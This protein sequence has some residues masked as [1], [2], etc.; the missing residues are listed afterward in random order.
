MRAPSWPLDARAPAAFAV[1]VAVALSSSGRAGADAD[2]ASL[3][4]QATAGLARTRDHDATG[5]GPLVG[6]SAR[7]TL[8][9]SDVWAYEVTAGGTLFASHHDG[10]SID[11]L[12]VP[13]LGVIDRYHLAGGLSVGA[14]ARFGVGWIPTLHVGVGL[15]ARHLAG[16]ELVAE[17][18]T[19]AS[20]PAL[21]SVD[22][23]G[24]LGLG[25]DHRLSRS[26]VVGLVVTAT[27]AQP[28]GGAAEPV[29]SL[30]ATV[31]VAWYFYPR[32]R[33]LA[34]W[35]GPTGVDP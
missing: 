27:H 22:V 13:V 7:F 31:H 35:R 16:S 5:T 25:L 20:L 1:A 3:H 30:D 6:A 14:H 18:T 24:S 8:A 23:T 9:R 4:G 15:Q 12:G 19:V 29:D 21:T 33:R 2:E 17:G 26:L 28:L 32:W 34:V 10:A 11:R